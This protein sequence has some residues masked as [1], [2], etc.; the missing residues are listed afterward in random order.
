MFPIFSDMN[1][2]K[3]KQKLLDDICAELEQLENISAIVL[4]GSFATG[5]ANQDSDLDIGI[6]YHENHPFSIDDIRGVAE[7]FSTIENP[8]VTDFY[9]WGPW[10]NGGAWINTEFGK[11]D[12]LYRNINQIRKTIQDA[13]E[14]KW[15]NHYEQQ[16]PYGFSSIFYL[17]EIEACQPIYDPQ[18]IIQY[19]KSLVKVYPENLKKTIIQESLWSAEFTLINAEGFAKNNDYFNSFGCFTRA[20]KN[21]VQVLFALNEIYP[22]TDKKAIEILSKSSYCPVKLE[23]KVKSILTAK[24]TLLENYKLL[25]SLFEETV[26][27]ASGFY[28]PLFSIKK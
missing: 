3:D 15:E 12:F 17:A 7:K 9:Q 24:S 26:S 20:L 1:L 21:I 25:L 10:V 19:L 23:Q 14:G 5:R 22:I 2:P 8:T 6:Y 13:T 28:Q 18:Q 16:P 11:V 27:L 4:G